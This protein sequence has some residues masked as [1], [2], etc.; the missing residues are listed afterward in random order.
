MEKQLSDEDKRGLRAVENWPRRGRTE[1]EGAGCGDR[2]GYGSICSVQGRKAEELSREIYWDI[3]LLIGPGTSRDDA[4]CLLK[5]MRDWIARA[6]EWP[7]FEHDDLP[8][9]GRHEY[10]LPD[11]VIQANP[12]ACR[13]PCAIC[14]KAVDHERGPVMAAA[15]TGSL[16]CNN[17]GATYAPLLVNVLAAYLAETDKLGTPAALPW[18]N[19]P[20]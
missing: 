7:M 9:K 19:N 10:T 1:F 13:A 4:L 18:K 15:R 3:K 11:N 8:S 5:Q 12:A 14:D 17:C 6:P 2:H 16:V 20:V